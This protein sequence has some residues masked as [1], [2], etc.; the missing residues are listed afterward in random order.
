MK[1]TKKVFNPRGFTLLEILAALVI[2]TVSIAFF[3]TVLTT[4]W[5]SYNDYISRSDLREECDIILEMISLSGRETRR[6]EVARNIDQQSASMFDFDNKPLMTFVMSSDGVF[7]MVRPGGAESILSRQMDY[8]RSSF[9][10]TGES[11]DGDSLIVNLA[12]QEKGLF[13]N[14]TIEGSTEIFPRNSRLQKQDL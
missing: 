2:T 5:Q 1:V 10:K 3:Y 14:V 6:I 11:Q 9:Q 4:N 13:R 8:A 12:L 7:K